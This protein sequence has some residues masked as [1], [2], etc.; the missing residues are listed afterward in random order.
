MVVEEKRGL[1]P[2]HIWLIVEVVT[3]AAVI[4]WYVWLR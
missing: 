1:R 2:W 4:A 3:V